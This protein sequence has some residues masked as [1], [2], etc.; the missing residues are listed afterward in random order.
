MPRFRLSSRLRFAS[1]SGQLFDE[2]LNV[3][4]PLNQPFLSGTRI[5]LDGVVAV[6]GYGRK[7]TK[8]TVVAEVYDSEMVV[9]AG[10]FVWL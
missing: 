3:A 5:N 4:V 9:Y 7:L 1:V 8:C 6:M 10:Q 2:F